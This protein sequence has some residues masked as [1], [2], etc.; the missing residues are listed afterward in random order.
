MVVL[1]EQIIVERDNIM[2]ELLTLKDEYST[3]QTNNSAIQEELDAKRIEIE[4][5]IEQAKKHQG[6]KYIIAKLRKESE[7]LR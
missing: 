3:L 1:K 5:L 7:T 6:D 2:A 4:E